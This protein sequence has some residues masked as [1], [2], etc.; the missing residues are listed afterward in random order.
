MLIAT[1]NTKYIRR[2]S[3]FHIIAFWIERRYSE[4]YSIKKISVVSR[5]ER[6]NFL[7]IM[8]KFL[9]FH[10]LKLFPILLHF[11]DVFCSVNKFFQKDYYIRSLRKF[12]Y[13]WIVPPQFFSTE[14]KIILGVVFEVV[15]PMISNIPENNSFSS[16]L[17]RHHQH[18]RISYVQICIH[19]ITPFSQKSLWGH[20]R[21]RLEALFRFWNTSK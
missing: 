2:V 19:V 10:F 9:I 17:L 11:T 14:L 3:R 13:D 18:D 12:W 4:I 5:S 16:L 1:N 15:W 21:E 20:V 7:K 6:S 8:Y